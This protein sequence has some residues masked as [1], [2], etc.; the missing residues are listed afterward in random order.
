M[1]LVDAE[2]FRRLLGYFARNDSS[3]TVA[4][5]ES[6]SQGSEC[7]DGSSRRVVI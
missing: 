7:S 1:M 3:L 6:N 4:Q 5:G 2:R